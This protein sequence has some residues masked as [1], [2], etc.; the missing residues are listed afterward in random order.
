[1]AKFAV[2]WL[3]ALLCSSSLH[4]EKLSEGEFETRVQKGILHIYNLEFEKA[5]SEFTALIR[6]RPENPAGHFFLAMVDWWKILIDMDNRQYD[7]AFLDSL[8]GVIDLC[9]ELLDKN[10]NDIDALFFKGGSIG[11]EGR[12]KFHRDDYLGAAAAG[13]DALPIIQDALAVDPKN[14]DIYLGTG[15]YNYFADII[16]DEYPWTKPLLLFL[17]SGDKKKGLQQLTVCSEK[18]KYA[19][20]ECTY[21]LL[22]IYYSYEKDYEKA[23]VLALSL[24]SRFPDNPLFH[25]YL[26]RCYVSLGNWPMVREVFAEIDRRAGSRRRGYLLSPWREAE[27]Y[28]GMCDMNDLQYELALK[29]FFKCDELSRSLDQEEVS[30]FMVMANLKA[31]MAYDALARRD[32]AEKQYRKVLDMRGYLNSHELAEGYLKVPFASR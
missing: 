12:L 3:M 1:M 29:H 8:D 14:Y 18:G 23:L 5:D 24:N 32:S 7:E 26:G 4:A 2:V 16:P 9:D 6:I 31:G 27:Y 19:N 10:K 30:G 22:Q 15:M 20:I 25:R 21:F 17:P 13:K 11:F 28:L